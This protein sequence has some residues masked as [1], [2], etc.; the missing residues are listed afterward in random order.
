AARKHAVVLLHVGD[1][2]LVALGLSVGRVPGHR[3]RAG[4]LIT[5]AAQ[6]RVIHGGPAGEQRDLRLHAEVGISAHEFYRVR[7][8]E[9]IEHAVDVLN[10]RDVGRVIRRHQGRPQLLDDLAAVVLEYALETGHLLVA[11]GE[12][13]GDG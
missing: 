9:A 7:S 11:E 3:D 5:E 6:Q 13:L 4:R 8:G 10:L 1:E 12:V 2:T